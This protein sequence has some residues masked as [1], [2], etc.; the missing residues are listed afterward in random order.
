MKNIAIFYFHIIFLL[1]ISYAVKYIKGP[2][3]PR[4]DPG[5]P[6]KPGVVGPKGEL[7]LRNRKK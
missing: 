1:S 4:G 3:G 2:K 5:P 7:I 6:G